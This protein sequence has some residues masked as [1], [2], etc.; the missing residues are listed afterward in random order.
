MFLDRRLSLM[1]QMGT[2]L[3]REGLRELGSSSQRS[4]SARRQFIQLSSD[5]GTIRWSWTGYVSLE[6][7]TWIDMAPRDAVG[8]DAASLAHSHRSDSEHDD[9]RPWVVTIH[10]GPPWERK[11]LELHFAS[12]KE[13]LQWAR[14]LE[15]LVRETA[16]ACSPA[17]KHFLMEMFKH[18][19]TFLSPPSP[20]QPCMTFL[21]L[22]CPPQ[23][24]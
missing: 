14:G 10:Y 20:P 21:S 2:S 17:M 8:G 7:V 16:L 9:R 22:S 5:L 19:G 12:G 13:A 15:A 6:D 18:A 1:M 3:H 4:R 24:R 11:C 23:C